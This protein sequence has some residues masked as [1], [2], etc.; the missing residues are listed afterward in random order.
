MNVAIAVIVYS[1]AQDLRSL[2]S[3]TMP[4]DELQ[5]LIASVMAQLVVYERY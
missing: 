2:L 4:Q 1:L 3:C 5:S